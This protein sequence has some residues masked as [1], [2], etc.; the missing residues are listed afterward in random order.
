M[1]YIELTQTCSRWRETKAG[2]QGAGNDVL[3][4]LVT[5]GQLA[6]LAAREDVKLRTRI[7]L[8]LHDRVFE[9]SHR[10]L[11]RFLR[12]RTHHDLVSRVC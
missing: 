8:H 1:R 11:I 12:K 10:Y 6:S 2:S 5:Q 9:V 3:N 7:P 4:D